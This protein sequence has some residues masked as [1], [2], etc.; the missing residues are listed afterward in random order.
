MA[1]TSKRLSEAERAE[2]RRRDRERLQRA[3]EEL[4]TSEGWKR[5]VRVRSQAGLALLSISNQLS[6]A[7]ARPDA[8]FVAGFNTWLRL[9]Y[10]V[11]K[12]ERAVAIIAP[13]P[14]KERDRVTGEE[15]GDT[16][17][18]FKTVFVFDRL[19][20]VRSGDVVDARA[21]TYVASPV[22][23]LRCLSARQC[24]T[25]EDGFG[26]RGRRGA[27][28]RRATAQRRSRMRLA[29]TPGSRSA[30][31]RHRECRRCVPD[32][33]NLADRQFA[34]DCRLA[35]IGAIWAWAPTWPLDGMRKSPDRRS[36]PGRP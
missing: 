13:L 12:G 4:L 33:G 17:M 29:G 24:H 2:R 34:E 31:C 18:L 26:M 6:V 19:S 36:R 27:G 1:K 5:W 22:P 25:G 14:V 28:A 15:T 35:P 16:M 3:T 20:R 8:T 11:R 23:R 7:L 32:T 21:G 30:M 9:G 10:A